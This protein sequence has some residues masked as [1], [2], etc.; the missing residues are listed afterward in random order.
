MGNPEYF[1]FRVL[2]Q[3]VGV[4]KIVQS[5][6]LYGQPMVVFDFGHD[7]CTVRTPDGIY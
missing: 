3:N 1:D 4:F 2:K 6:V 5:A 7:K